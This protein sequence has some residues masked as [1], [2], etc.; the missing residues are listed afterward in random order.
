VIYLAT[1]EDI[2]RSTETAAMVVK[3]DMILAE[4]F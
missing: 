1:M 2:V 4:N 3:W